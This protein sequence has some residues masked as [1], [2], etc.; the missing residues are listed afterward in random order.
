MQLQT[1]QSK[2][3]KINMTIQAPSKA[4]KTYS[5]LL[6]AAFGLC[7]KCNYKCTGYSFVGNEDGSHLDLVVEE[8]NDRVK[9]IYDCSDFLCSP[10]KSKEYGEGIRVNRDDIIF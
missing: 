10:V 5:A 7:K 8:K 1:A 4:S 3:A 6:V 2:R 9:D